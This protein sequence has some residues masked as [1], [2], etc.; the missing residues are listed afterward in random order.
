VAEGGDYSLHVHR[1]HNL[2]KG[3]AE[4]YKHCTME[5]SFH[6]L[7]TVWPYCYKDVICQASANLP[8]KDILNSGC[9]F[10]NFYII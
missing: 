5:M 8:D 4:A 10:N 3:M 6:L 1:A 2:L 9:I 7:N